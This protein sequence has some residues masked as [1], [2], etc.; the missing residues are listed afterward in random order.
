SPAEDAAG[1]AAVEPEPSHTTTEQVTVRRG[2]TLMNILKRAGVDVGEAHAA[3]ASLQEVYDP[4]RL[5]AGQE[6]ALELQAAETEDG[7]RQVLLAGLSLGLNFQQDVHLRRSEEEGFAAA[8]VDRTL[9]R[10]VAL[11][12]GAIDDSLY[13]SAIR[14]GLPED[15]LLELIR[16]FSWDVDFQREIQPNDGFEVLFE[17]ISTEDGSEVRGGDLLFANLTL[18]GRTLTAYRYEHRDGGVD[19]F[20]GE[21][22]TLRKSLLRTPID[23]A[24]L[25]SRFGPRRH[26]IL[27]Y[28]KMHRG[29]D[30]A[31]PTGTPIYAAGEGRVVKIGRNGGYGNYIRIQHNDE[32]A[33][34]YAHLK[35]FARGLKHGSRVRQGDVIGYLGSTGLST[36][37]HLHYEVH[38]SGEQINPLSIKQ[39]VAQVLAG[40]ELARFREHVAA[41]DARRAELA[42]GTRVA[43]RLA[44]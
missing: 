6:I 9:H 27:G 21:G 11:T 31:A 41:I 44:D 17:R 34:A 16:L 22:R 42:R 19:Y 25:S 18:S 35:G 36:G 13:L 40:G 5:Q 43:S 7:G 38:R 3:I 14:A 4:R 10:R 33:T 39:T 32:Y 28:N 23:G 2:D 12:V 37:P 20:D 26:P 8:T 24:R 30:F 15:A 29:I 1:A